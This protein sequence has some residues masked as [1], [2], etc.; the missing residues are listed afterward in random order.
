MIFG[1]SLK[2]LPRRPV[3]RA[4]AFP[5]AETSARLLHVA[6][7]PAF[8]IVANRAVGGIRA[9]GRHRAHVAYSITE[10]QNGPALVAGQ[11]WSLGLLDM[12][13]TKNVAAYQRISFLM[14]VKY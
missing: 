10:V 13:P 4:P 14:Q 3:G 1:A 8:S 5:V 12:Y 11:P 7:R 2:E 9:I 6:G